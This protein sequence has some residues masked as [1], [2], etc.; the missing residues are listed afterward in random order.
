MV[1][2][3]SVVITPPSRRESAPIVAL[4]A[5]PAA[6]ARSDARHAVH[7]RERRP[8]LDEPPDEDGRNDDLEH[9]P[10]RLA[11]RGPERERAVVVRQEVADEDARHVPKPEEVD[12]RHADADRQPDDRGHRS[13]ELEVEAELSSAVVQRHEHREPDEVADDGS[14]REHGPHHDGPMLNH[15][16]APFAIPSA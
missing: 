5:T 2:I 14:P 12:E 11:D 15:G 9:V 13:G 16:S 1:G 8:P 10:D 3:A 4:T 7:R 6:I